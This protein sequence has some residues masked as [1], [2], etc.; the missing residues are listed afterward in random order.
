MINKQNVIKGTIILMTANAISKILGAVFKIPLT[1]ILKEEGMAIY[2]TAF[3]VYIMLLSFIISGIPLAISKMTAEEAARHNFANVRK[4]IFVSLVLLSFLGVAG[5][6]IIYFGADFFAFSMKEPKAVFCLKIIAPSVFFVTVGTVFKSCFQ[7]LSDMF[8]TA[9]S[10]VVEAV[11]KLAAG[12]TL[13]LYFSHTA[14]EYTAAATIMGVTI[15]EI[16][17][18]FILFVL[19]LP[20]H[21]KYI[22]EKA[23]KKNNEILSNIASIAIPSICA[24]A[25]SAAM[26]LADISV[27]RSCLE[28][29]TFTAK[30]AE[31]FL[32]QY[33]GYTNIFDS[34]QTDL[35]ITQTGSRWLYGAYSGYALTVFHLPIGILSALGV[36]ILPVIAGALAAGNRKRAE[37][38]I[39]SAEKFTI[40][41]SVPAAFFIAF[42]SEEIMY[43]LFKNTASAQMLSLLAP[44]LFFISLSQLFSS[45][46]NADGKIIFP[47]AIGFLGSVIKILC[48]IIFITN[49]NINMLGTVIGANI[50]Y[51]IVMMLS[52]RYVKKQFPFLDNLKCFFIKTVLSSLI[53]VTVIYILYYPFLVI[54]YSETLSLLFSFP[55]GAIVYILLLIYSSCLSKED[56]SIIKSK[57]IPHCH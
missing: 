8:P 1:Y 17:A 47:L 36:S 42:F 4:I 51:F 10:Q 29:I 19:Y 46:L 22:S 18:T 32:L 5:S 49:P 24:S 54:F 23:D 16:I 30:S 56:L 55:V 9:V 15:G 38:C 2:N 48:N 52:Y 20:K 12:Y 43:I 50:S 11:I 7:G 6:M 28:R 41:I 34:L 40:I 53:S 35:K 44:S 25:L 33:S 26:N 21:F 27:I 39:I 14:I 57:N 13:A 31:N 37:S 3:N 45:I